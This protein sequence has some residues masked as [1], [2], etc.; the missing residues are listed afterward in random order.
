[1]LGSLDVM[2]N[3]KDLYMRGGARFEN[4]FVTTPIC[5]PSRISLL[6]GRWAH[7]SG[8]VAT[9]AAGWCAMVSPPGRVNW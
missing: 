6:S 7:N 5:C 1:M 3:T 4:F 9:T 2:N 8:A